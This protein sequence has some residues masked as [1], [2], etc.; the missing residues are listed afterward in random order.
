MRYI[1]ESQASN[2]YSSRLPV[3]LHIVLEGGEF[4]LFDIWEDSDIETR[5]K[6]LDQATKYIDSFVYDGEKS[7]PDQDNEFPRKGQKQ[8]P[9]EIKDCTLE[10]ALFYLFEYHSKR[11]RDGYR[12]RLLDDGVENGTITIAEHSER[13]VFTRRDPKEVVLPYIRRWLKGSYR[14]TRWKR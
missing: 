6:A 9:E 8:L 2:R 14:M 12:A 13:L 4:E 1:S 10:L 11:T 7:D 5:E 3:N